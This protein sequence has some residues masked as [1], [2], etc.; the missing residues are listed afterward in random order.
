MLKRHI[1]T[2][3]NQQLTLIALL[4]P[5]SPRP[6]PILAQIHFKMENNSRGKIMQT[7]QLKL[8]S[9]TYKLDVEGDILLPDSNEKSC[10]IDELK[11][12]L[13][14]PVQCPRL[15]QLAATASRA[16]IVI[17]D[18]TRISRSD[19]LLPLIIDELASGGFDKSTITLI[20]ANG[21]H[22]P[23]DNVEI[24][25][26]VGQHVASGFTILQHDSRDLRTLQPLCT[27]TRGTEV[28]LNKNLFQHD[29]VVALGSINAH[30]FAGFGGGR[31]LIFP[32]L[33]GYDGIIHNHLLSVDFKACQLAAGVKPGNLKGNPVH[34]DFEEIVSHIPPK[35]MISVLLNQH[36]Q[37]SAIYTG[38]WRVSHQLACDEFMNR[39]GVT[40]SE[41][42][43]AIIASCGGYPKDIDLVQS[44]KSIQH[45]CLALKPGGK[46]LLMAECR[47]GLG[48]PDFD[49]HFPMHD[50]HAFCKKLESES[51]KNGQ[52][53][54]ALQQKANEFDIGLL[55]SLPSELLNDIGLQYFENLES[56]LEW[57][58]DSE[59]IGI[60]PK[61]S[62]T[63]PNLAN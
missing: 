23:L 55:T 13:Q 28:W 31:K 37:I 35:F 5:Y 51:I 43:D 9:E 47:D 17:P 53:A 61:A 34:E 15:A 59:S 42:Y 8:G 58:A 10:S 19:V 63:I 32:G 49:Q 44:H 38:D 40:L 14:Q 56:G 16:L 39:H 12:A 33:A 60:M 57:V 25:S 27:S 11:T 6:Y 62:V 22:R 30:Y 24:E 3:Q 26:L 46:L 2:A 20:V 29:L 7:T 36:D 50:P 18:N 54:L 45:A 48:S 1:D 4:S 41:K 52:T 21:T